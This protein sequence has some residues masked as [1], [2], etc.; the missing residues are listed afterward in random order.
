[1]LLLQL[2]H[3]TGSSRNQ[4]ASGTNTAV[5]IFVMREEFDACTPC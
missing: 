1:V 4:T 2:Y 3:D 5:Q